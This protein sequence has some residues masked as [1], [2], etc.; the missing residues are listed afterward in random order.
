MTDGARKGQKLLLGRK[1]QELQ[2][3]EV[4][5]DY[6]ADWPAPCRDAFDAFHTARQAM[7]RQMDASIASHAD[8]ETLYDQPA[9]A[10]DKLRITGPFTVEAVPFPTV[11]SLE[12][13]SV[14]APSALE[15]DLAIARSGATSRQSAA[16]TS[17]SIETKKLIA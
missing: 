12:K 13:Q 2:E 4:P 10:K 6:P 3:W 14:Q 11:L 17:A 15:A 1:G 9:V 16:K 5:F 8:N 7:Q